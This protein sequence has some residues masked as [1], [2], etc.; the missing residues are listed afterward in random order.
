M[1]FTFYTFACYSFT[2]L[3]K[4]GMGWAIK[5]GALFICGNESIVRRGDLINTQHI[6][7]SVS[8]SHGVLEMTYSKISFC[9]LDARR[10]N[11]ALPLLTH[12]PLHSFKMIS[13]SV[14]E[15]LL[16]NIIS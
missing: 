1:K 16:F 12:V 4:I 8:L 9:N 10:L 2:D 13:P 14:L 5:H 7:G 15:I 6:Y 11:Y 3:L